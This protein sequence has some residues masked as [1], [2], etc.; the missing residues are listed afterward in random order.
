MAIEEIARKHALRNAFDYGR[1]E[2]GSVVGKVIAEAPEAKGD[3]KGTMEIVKKIVGEVNALS[4][5]DV[6]KALSAFTFAEKREEKKG[7]EL[8]N[9]EKGKVVTRLPP[10]PSGYLHIGHAKAA[11]LDYEAARAYGGKFILRFDDTDPGKESQEFVDTTKDALK[12]LGISWDEE[13]YTSDFMPKLY[14]FADRMVAEGAAYVCTCKQEEVRKNRGEGKECACRNE[15]RR[16]IWERMKKGEAAEGEA[17]VRLK[18][19]MKSLNTV[20]RDPMLFRI[21]KGAHYRQGTK[22]AAWP[23]Y[24][25]ACPIVD[26]ITGVTHAMRTKEYELRDE[27]YYKMI[28]VLGL[29]KPIIVEFARLAIKNAPLSKRLLKPLIEEKKV[30]GWSDP[31]LPTLA[32]LRRRGIMPEAIKNFVLSFGIAKAESEP[33]WDALLAENRKALDPVAERYFF[34]QNPVELVVENATR[35]KAVLKKHPSRDMGVRIVETGEKFYISISDAQFLKEGE[36]FRLKE[37]YNVKVKEK[38]SVIKGEYAGKEL[39]DGKK[40]QWVGEK[41][42]KAKVLVPK[43]L[44]V[45]GK[46]NENSLEVDEGICELACGELSEGAVIQFERYGFCRLDNWGE[47]KFILACK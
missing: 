36:T 18:G 23:S 28:D 33:T 32:A 6:E 43:D 31:R 12:W 1:A 42:L 35:E 3:M 4:K 24:D 22:Y 20:M 11:F 8:P 25:F 13:L 7:I 14:E 17:H 40:I 46:F 38:G 37:L 41:H 34:V 39:L 26:S 5:G 10:E 2:A 21:V 47:M 44:F 27:L 19:D 9:A 45:D 15:I 29:R 30:D 16:E